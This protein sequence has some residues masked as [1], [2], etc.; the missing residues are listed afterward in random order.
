MPPRPR[1]RPRRRAGHDLRHPVMDLTPPWDLVR[2]CDRCA[3]AAS[4]S[5]CTPSVPINRGSRLRRPRRAPRTGNGVYQAGFEP[6]PSVLDPFK[7]RPYLVPIEM[8]WGCFTFVLARRRPRNWPSTR[9]FRRFQWFRRRRSVQRG[10]EQR[11]TGTGAGVRAGSNS[12]EDPQA[13]LEP[14]QWPGEV[15]LSRAGHVE[16]D[17]QFSL[18][19]VQSPSWK[20]GSTRS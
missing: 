4:S 1:E 15:H 8:G 19:V 11:R 12:G 3:V 2:S 9:D 10:R 5:R 18:V 13:W 6:G 16:A 20:A 14:G 7:P 17:P